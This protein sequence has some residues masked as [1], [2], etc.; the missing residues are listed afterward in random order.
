MWGD[1]A[2][3]KQSEIACDRTPINWAF[4]KKRKKRLGLPAAFILG[5]F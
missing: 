2:I 4:D 1:R 5:E 3:G